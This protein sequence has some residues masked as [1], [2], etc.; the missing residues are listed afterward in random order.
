[1][2]DSKITPKTVVSLA[3][4]VLLIVATL[5]G[6][7]VP[8]E[9][10]DV[11]TETNDT[12]DTSE[13]TPTIAEDDE[14]NPSSTDEV[15]HPSADTLEESPTDTAETNVSTDSA[16]VENETVEDADV[17]NGDNVADPVETEISATEGDVENA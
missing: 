2:N 15:E 12:V 16:P 8:Y 3:L 17:S 5:F 14:Q 4:V 13:V 11:I 6:I 10:E 1:M 7:N 9:L